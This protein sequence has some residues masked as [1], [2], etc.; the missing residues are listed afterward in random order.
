MENATLFV[1]TA[2]SLVLGGGIALGAVL[3]VS[4]AI[5]VSRAVRFGRV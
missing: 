1:E 2:R 4:L 3:S 5:L